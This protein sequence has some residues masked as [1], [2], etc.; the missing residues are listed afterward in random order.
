MTNKIENASENRL[1]V[2]VSSLLPIVIFIF[3][4]FFPKQTDEDIENELSA[5]Y[6]EETDPW[7]LVRI[8][9]FVFVIFFFLIAML[10]M[11]KTSLTQGHEAIRVESTGVLQKSKL[12]A[13]ERQRIGK[14]QEMQ[15]ARNAPVDQNQ[16]N[17]QENLN[18][19]E[20]DPGIGENNSILARDDFVRRSDAPQLS[21]ADGG[22]MGPG[23]ED[24]YHG[25]RR[26]NI[27]QQDNSGLS[28]NE[29]MPPPPAPPE[30]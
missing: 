22:A 25:I 5:E 3:F 20:Y 21:G 28:Q 11:L 16:R 19:G 9:I 18:E 23:N 29:S 6:Q 7:L 27:N 13:L 15:A 17:S 24:D 10:M 8:I 2:I 14:I 12:D 26:R 1:I 30:Y 4:L